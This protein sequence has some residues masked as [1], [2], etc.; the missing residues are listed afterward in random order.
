M[1]YLNFVSIC[2]GHLHACLIILLHTNTKIVLSV[3]VEAIKY[4]LQYVPS[5]QALPERR[6]GYKAS[7][8]HLKIFNL[9]NFV[10]III[11]IGMDPEW[12]ID[13]RMYRD[14]VEILDDEYYS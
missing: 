2:L 9:K 4:S 3:V 12:W 6:P 1:S 13:R 7:S 11:K 5:T 8:N 14:I 10:V